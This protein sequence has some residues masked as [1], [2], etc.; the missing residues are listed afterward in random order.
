VTGPIVYPLYGRGRALV[1]F[2][3]EN[4]NADNIAQAAMF[5]CGACSCEV[6]ALNPGVDLLVS[7]DW[8]GGLMGRAVKDPPLPPLVSLSELAAAAQPVATATPAP[9]P[10][11]PTGTSPLL[12]NVVIVLLVAVAVLAI[13]SKALKSKAG[14]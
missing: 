5:L 6:K 3:P 13:A 4:L 11:E 9:A 12:R 10:A 2:T 1:A 7:A 14:N 8:D